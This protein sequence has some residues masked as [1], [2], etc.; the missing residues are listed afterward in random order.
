MY[1]S[2]NKNRDFLGLL[3]GAKRMRDSDKDGVPNIFD[4]AP[5]NPN[6]DA[7]IIPQQLLQRRPEYIAEQIRKRKP[8][9]LG[10]QEQLRRAEQLRRETPGRIQEMQNQISSLDAE[11]YA[12]NYALLP[13]EI[14]KQFPAP[15]EIKIQSDKRKEQE[16]QSGIV[17]QALRLLRRKE[18]GKP[19][20][21]WEKP[22]DII[23]LVNKLDN[24]GSAEREN[25]LRQAYPET[26]PEYI[27]AVMNREQQILSGT[28]MAGKT[29]QYAGLDVGEKVKIETRTK[30]GQLISTETVQ[31]MRIGKRVAPVTIAGATFGKAEQALTS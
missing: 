18:Q 9:T 13:E 2:N 30:G 17:A 15:S 27:K 3:A 10:E 7:P 8:L 5:N 4:C 16:R 24:M 23:R 19:F 26:S 29:Y 14:Q 11:G 28:Q 12:K 31:G 20:W 22:K 21:G 25:Y 6:R 1:K